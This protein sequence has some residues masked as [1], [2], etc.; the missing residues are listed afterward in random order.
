MI[1]PFMRRVNSQIHKVVADELERLKDPRLGFVTVTGVRT[2]PDL[3]NSTIYYSI[4][5]GDAKETADA[6]ASAAG[7]MRTAVGRR[8]RLKFV[9]AFQFAP[10]HG[11]EDGLRVDALLRRIAE[12]SEQH[13]VTETGDAPEA[14]AS[15]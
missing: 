3:G 14:E 6:L 11:I 13:Q 9:P 7:K 10:D 12:E 1:S 15:E 4:L 2:S 8:V 5:E